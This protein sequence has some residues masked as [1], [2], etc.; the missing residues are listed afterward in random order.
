MCIEGARSAPVTGGV[1]CRP[2][3]PL[4]ESWLGSAERL[5]VVGYSFRDDHVNQIIRRWTYDHRAREIILIDPSIPR[6][7]PSVTSTATFR[8]SLLAHLKPSGMSEGP[9]TKIR[10]IRKRAAQAVPE[11][12][13]GGR[14]VRGVRSPQ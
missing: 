4:P 9:E 1:T 12:F 6:R 3:T 8:N 10:V 5:T 7:R 11:L 13:A 14:A 2:V